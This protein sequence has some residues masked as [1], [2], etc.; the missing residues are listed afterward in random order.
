MR[1]KQDQKIAACG[2]A[3]MECGPGD[4]ALARVDLPGFDV[5]LRA[6]EKRPELLR[7]GAPDPPLEGGGVVYEARVLA[8]LTT[9]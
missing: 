5:Q 7:G 4:A 9:Q 1:Q 3:Y 2:S 6:Q 8:T